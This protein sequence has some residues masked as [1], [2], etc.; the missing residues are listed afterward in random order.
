MTA[1][2][3]LLLKRISRNDSGKSEQGRRDEGG[4]Q[5]NLLLV[6]TSRVQRLPLEEQIAV[7]LNHLRMVPFVKAVTSTPT[8]SLLTDLGIDARLEIVTPTTAI[9]PR[10]ST[11]SR[12][13]TGAETASVA[14]AT[15]G[16]G[17]IARTATA[18]ATH[19]FLAQVRHT[20]LHKTDLN[21]LANL[22]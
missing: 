10:I 17:A 1:P 14:T 9:E 2:Y 15:A 19:P 22:A 12:R 3:H 20:Y 13:T 5:H 7:H 8:D 18:I 16:A 4:N 21:T 6:H 11:E